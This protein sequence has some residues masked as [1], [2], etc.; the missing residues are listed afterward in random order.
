[1]SIVVCI[2]EKSRIIRTI[3]VVKTTD[4][5]RL[6]QQLVVEKQKFKYFCLKIH[7]AIKIIGATIINRVYPHHYIIY[8]ARQSN[9]NLFLL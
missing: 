5:N 3:I 8:N 1:M 2:C 7:E 6:L 4:G 9:L